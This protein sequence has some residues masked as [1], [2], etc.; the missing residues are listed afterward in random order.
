MKLNNEKRYIPFFS[1]HVSLH[2]WDFET[3]DR[4]Y[5]LQETH[6]AIKKVPKESQIK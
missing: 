5:L 3:D 1:I 2:F 4:G 6:I